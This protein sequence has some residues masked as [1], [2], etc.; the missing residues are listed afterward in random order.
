MFVFG[1]TVLTAISR[2]DL[3]V[4][5]TGYVASM[6]CDTATTA[7]SSSCVNKISRVSGSSSAPVMFHWACWSFLQL[8]GLGSDPNTP[9]LAFG[10]RL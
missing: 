5:E 1:F 7:N 6:R 9:A 8:A 4:S 3:T 10:G 2:S